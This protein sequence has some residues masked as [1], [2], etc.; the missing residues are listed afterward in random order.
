MDPRELPKFIELTE[1]D[2]ARFSSRWWDI[3]ADNDA[4][5]AYCEP[6]QEELDR[7]FSNYN[8]IIDSL[9][10]ENARLRKELGKWNQQK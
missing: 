3:I 8:R 7:I 9:Q 4:F 10:E 6:D 5:E 1:D 2:A